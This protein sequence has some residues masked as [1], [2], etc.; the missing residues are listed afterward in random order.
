MALCGMEKATIKVK[1]SKLHCPFTWEMLD[2]VIKYNTCNKN[3]G[4]DTLDD[5]ASCNLEL[6][7]VYLLKCYKSILSADNDVT[8]TIKIAEELLMELQQEYDI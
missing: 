3:S 7:M 4:N 1:L 8:T 2:S 6:L 5:E